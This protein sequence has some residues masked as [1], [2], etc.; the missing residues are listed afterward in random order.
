MSP[1]TKGLLV[2]GAV[3]L[4]GGVA[5]GGSAWAVAQRQHAAVLREEPRRAEV[6]RLAALRRKLDLDDDQEARVRAI[7]D[8]D[9]DDS[10]ALGR[11]MMDRCGEPLRDHKTA[12]DAQI[13]EALRPDQR[14][15]FDK[16]TDERRRR[17]RLGDAGSR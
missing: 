13:R 12:V 5:G 4:L 10:R 7:L 3:F 11:D 8:R 6:R 1:R 15:R 16:L 9:A 14:A 17:V 2:L